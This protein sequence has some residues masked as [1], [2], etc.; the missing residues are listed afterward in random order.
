M[1][2]DHPSPVH[3]APHPYRSRSDPSIRPPPTHPPL[4]TRALQGHPPHRP[5]SAHSHEGPGRDE[6]AT[7]SFG[8]M[9]LRWVAPSTRNVH[10]CVGYILDRYPASSTSPRSFAQRI[11][12]RS[13]HM[14][15]T[16]PCTTEQPSTCA[17]T[18][19]P[20]PFFGPIPPYL[21]CLF[22]RPD[23]SGELTVSCFTVT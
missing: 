2:K 22:E 20:P 7:R 5:R 21:F 23:G 16:S 17:P 15:S 14:T 12:S 1:A 9:K 3:G 11:E 4:P 18:Y 8:K 13:P 10:C 19:G 6:P